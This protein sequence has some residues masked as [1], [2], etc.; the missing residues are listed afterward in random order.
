[1]ADNKDEIVVKEDKIEEDKHYDYHDHKKKVM[2]V[3]FLLFLLLIALGLAGAVAMRKLAVNR[4]VGTE[5]VAQGR[6][7]ELRGNRGGMMGGRN[8]MFGQSSNVTQ[9]KVTAVDG[10][11]I[12]ID[13]S[14]TTKAVQI[15]TDTRFPL[16]STTKIAVGDTISVVGEQDSVG[17]IQALRVI[18][19]PTTIN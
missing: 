3:G 7:F 10:Q 18:V 2:L 8:M 4:I 12:T 9:G 13:A 16:N 15:G 19:N 11:K 5:R 6:N 14:G 17:V 1:M